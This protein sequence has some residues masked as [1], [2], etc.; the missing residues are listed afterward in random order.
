MESEQVLKRIAAVG[1]A[2]DDLLSESLD[3]LSPSDLT[4]AAAAWATVVRRLPVLD[5]RIVAALNRVPPAELGEKTLKRAL[6]TLLRISG[7]EANRLISDAENLAPRTTLTGQP[8]APLMSATAA[9]QAR[10]AIGAEHVTII[11]KFLKDL[12]SWVDVDTREQA[13]VDLA[14]VAAHHDPDGLQKAADRLAYLLDQDGPEPVD[15]DLNC[16]GT[17]TIGKQRPNGMSRIQGDIDPEGRAVWEAIFATEAAPGACN[18]N[19]EN[20]CV[21]GKPDEQHVTSD[22][23][24]PGQ[25]RHDAFKAVG[26]AILASGQLGQHK[27]LPVTVI[28]STTLKELESGAGHGVTGGGSLLPMRDLIRLASQA[29]HYLT[30]F[31]EHTGVPL[32]LARAKRLASPGQRIVLHARDRGCTRPACTVPGYWCEANHDDPW[33]TGG[34]TDVTTMS[35]ACGPDNRMLHETGWSVRRRK[36]GRTEWIPPP[37]L[38]TGQARINFYHHPERY[39]I[40]DEADDDDGDGDG[41]DDGVYSPR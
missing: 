37:N 36:D 22:T 16:K 8:M 24:T 14:E 21:D 25:R 7:K 28:V 38:D 26:R 4:A 33:S 31:D 32:A 5:N 18:P 27:G 40:P 13:E 3:G 1:E 17:V 34:H 29:H 12:P 41:D 10:G 6:C 2:F 19:D 35:F 39:L 11:A 20:P 15:A 9:A 23:R 30:V